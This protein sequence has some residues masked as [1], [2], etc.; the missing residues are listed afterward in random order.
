MQC[1]FHCASSQRSFL[2]YDFPLKTFCETGEW[3]YLFIGFQYIMIGIQVYLMCS[4]LYSFLSQRFFILKKLRC[5]GQRR[6][7]TMSETITSILCFTGFLLLSVFIRLKKIP[8]VSLTYIIARPSEKIRMKTDLK[9]IHFTST[10]FLLIAGAFVLIFFLTL[11]PEVKAL[12]I[13]NY[14]YFSFLL[15]YV[16][17][18]SIQSETRPTDKPDV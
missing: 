14:A 6:M 17:Y 9:E 7:A 5:A 3:L 1:L 11:F 13:A 16:F 8:P 12:E 2:P 4:F 10:L 15:I 18:K